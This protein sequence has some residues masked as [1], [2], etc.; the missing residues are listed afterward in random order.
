MTVMMHDAGDMLSESAKQA[1]DNRNLAD[2]TFADDPLLHGVSPKHLK[3]FLQ[4]VSSAE[5]RYGIIWSRITRW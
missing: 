1:Y 3:E 4:V 5:H 2:L